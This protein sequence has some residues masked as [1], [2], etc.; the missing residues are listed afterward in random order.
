[1]ET[2]R[3]AMARDKAAMA[4]TA[5]RVDLRATLQG[6]P[7]KATAKAAMARDK[8]DSVRDRAVLEVASTETVRAQDRALALS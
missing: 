7:N 8:A 4:R 2:V 3:E 6:Q 5:S 1:M